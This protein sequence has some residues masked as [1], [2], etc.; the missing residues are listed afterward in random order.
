MLTEWSTLSGLN[1]MGKANQGGKERL[2]SY[3]SYNNISFKNGTNWKM[4]NSIF[5]VRNV[6]TYG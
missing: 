2:R 5:T 6:E 1:N 4:N 3:W